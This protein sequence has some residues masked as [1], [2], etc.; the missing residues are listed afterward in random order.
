[1]VTRSS[2][3][4]NHGWTLRFLN[5]WKFDTSALTYGA[6]KWQREWT[7][8]WEYRAN[9]CKR[10]EVINGSGYNGDVKMV[11]K[12]DRKAILKRNSNCKMLVQPWQAMS[13]LPFTQPCHT[14]WNHRDHDLQHLACVIFW[15]HFTLPCFAIARLWV[16]ICLVRFSQNAQVYEYFIYRFSNLLPFTN[17]LQV[18]ILLLLL[19]APFWSRFR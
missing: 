16:A 5:S 6:V 14:T 19:P 10:K 3:L 18:Q 12:W 7:M 8:K 17:D 11:L 13:S 15:F 2:G 9:R 4:L 1:M